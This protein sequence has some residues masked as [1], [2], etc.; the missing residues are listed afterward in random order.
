MLLSGQT[1]KTAISANPGLDVSKG[2]TLDAQGLP[3]LGGR[4][5]AR[6]SGPARITIYGLVAVPHGSSA[7]GPPHPLPVP[8]CIRVPS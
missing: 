8:R 4:P 7:D 1:D 6:L 2:S 5:S 3:C